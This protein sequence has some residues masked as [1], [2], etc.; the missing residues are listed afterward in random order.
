V[1]VP[2]PALIVLDVNETLS[3]MRPLRGLLAELDAPPSLAESWFASTLRDGFALTAAGSYAPFPA[4]ARI[5]LGPY[6]DTV[7]EAF[8]RLDVHPDV[9]EGIR[10][11]HALGIRL[12]TMSN[13]A[14]SIAE[15][16]LE[17]AGVAGLVEQPLS[18]DDVRHWKPAREAYLHAVEF[19]GVHPADAMLVAVHPWDVDGAKR[20]GL[21]A[22]WLD[23]DAGSYPSG[24]FTEP[25]VQ[26]TTLLGLADALSE[27]RY[28][29]VRR[30]LI[31]LERSIERELQWVVFEPNDEATWRGVV[32]TVEAE[33]IGVWRSG[34]LQGAKAEEAFLVR[35]DR[36]TMTQDDID[37]G[38]LVCLVGVAPMRPAE[39]VLFRIGQW[40][41]EV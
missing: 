21:Q 24:V 41:A 37:N 20:A 32:S 27:W 30:F 38:R 22:G 3:D 25:D 26:A 5:H 9:P 28:V 29:N 19:C 10:K 16:L 39:F 15:G 11:L 34:A 14:S 6:A 4:I 31:A 12:V 13:G 1:R 17:R 7:L 8:G 2:R 40:T 23:R 18:V 36:T 33:L 35:C